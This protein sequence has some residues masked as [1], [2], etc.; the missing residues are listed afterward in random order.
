MLVRRGPL[1]L[2]FLIYE[3]P[4]LAG[5]S[6]VIQQQAMCRQ[7]VAPCTSD[8]LVITFNTL[9]QIKMDHEAHIRLIDAHAKCN[10][11]DDD[12]RVVPDEGFLVVPACMVFKPGMIR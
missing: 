3:I 9:R 5:I 1:G 11:R 4:E 12:L 10:R 7:T 2:P 8:L 6:I